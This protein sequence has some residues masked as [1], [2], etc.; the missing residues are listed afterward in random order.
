MTT[1]WIEISVGGFVIAGSLALLLLAFK[2]SG[3]DLSSDDKNAYTVYAH[4]NNIGGL[5]PR[6]KVTM[7]GV[8]IG[9]VSAVEIDSQWYDAKVTLK[10]DN[11]MRNKLSTDTTA[12]ILTSGLLGE[13][14]IG[15]VVGAEEEMLADGGEIRDTQPALVLED[16]IGKFL[17]SMGKE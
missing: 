15:L 2:V 11:S 17:S 16:L 9:R 7:A 3:L 6:A 14:Y 13:N 5:K 1:R 4:F 8:T 12:M 10:I